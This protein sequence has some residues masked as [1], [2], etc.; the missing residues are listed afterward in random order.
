MYKSIEVKD[1]VQ[2]AAK[3]ANMIVTAN[4]A[5]EAP[6]LRAPLV[7]VEEAPEEV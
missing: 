6:C 5:N 1:K 2:A 3:Q 4:T 7:G